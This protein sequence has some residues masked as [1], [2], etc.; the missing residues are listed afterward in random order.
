MNRSC[1]QSRKLQPVKIQFVQQLQIWILSHKSSISRF[2]IFLKSRQMKILIMQMLYCSYAT[3]AACCMHLVNAA[4]A[5]GLNIFS[6]L[7]A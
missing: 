7:W 3:L 4:Y 5:L 2:L 1:R 6:N